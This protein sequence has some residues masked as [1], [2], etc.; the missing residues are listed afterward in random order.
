MRASAPRSAPVLPAPRASASARG[1][2]CTTARPSSA[3]PFPRPLQNDEHLLKGMLDKEKAK[4]GADEAALRAILEKYSVT[5][6][7]IAAVLAW[8]Q[9]Q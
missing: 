6:A 1:W 7:D 8:K 4:K 5:D 9:R 2:W 3:S